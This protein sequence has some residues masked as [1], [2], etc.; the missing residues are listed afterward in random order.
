MLDLLQ[1]R[2]GFQA[3]LF[4]KASADALIRRQSFFLPPLTVEG[5]DQQYPEALPVGIR[6]DRGFELT[7][8]GFTKPQSR[9]EACLHQLHSRLLQPSARMRSPVA[10]S[11]QHLSAKER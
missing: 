2:T 5:G 11:R 3:E 9:C 7:G 6:P 1:R 10:G 4:C 8:D